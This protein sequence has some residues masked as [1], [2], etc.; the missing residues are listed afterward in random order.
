MSVRSYAL[1]LTCVLS[2]QSMAC[3]DEA[4]AAA[5]STEPKVKKKSRKD[6]APEEVVKQEAVPRFELPID[7]N[8]SARTRD[9]CLSYARE[10]AC[11]TRSSTRT[12]WRS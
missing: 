12:I 5:G 10:A 7:C 6:K 11:A 9:P 8:D 2:A 4:P 1:I 3:N